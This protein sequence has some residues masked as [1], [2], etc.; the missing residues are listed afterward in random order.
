M[1]PEDLKRTQ[2]WNVDTNSARAGAT[3]RAETSTDWRSYLLPLSHMVG[4]SL[5][6]WGVATGLTVS[7]MANQEGLTIAPGVGL[8]AAGQLIALAEDG[9]A[10]TDPTVDPD[11]M[12]NVPTVPVDTSGVRLATTGLQ[13]DYVVTIRWREVEEGNPPV[14]KQTP[15]GAAAPRGG[16]PRHGRAIVS[17]SGHARHES[18]RD[19]V[20]ANRQTVSRSAG[21][22]D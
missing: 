1:S 18:P 9:F 20:N 5:H 8:D 10:I 12:R 22:T 2:Y 4:A 16:V 3:Q 11:Q 21:R 13:G 15:L 19:S 17:G 6:T 14:L 7:A